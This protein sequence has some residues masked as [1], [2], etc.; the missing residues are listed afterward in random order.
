MRNWLQ[1]LRD[2]F[3]RCE[4]L[5]AEILATVSKEVRATDKYFIEN[6]FSNCEMTYLATS[7]YMAEWLSNLEPQHASTPESSPVSQCQNSF[8]S[9]TAFQLPRI[10]LPKFSGDLGEWE[11]FRDQFKSLINDNNDLVNVNR[12]QYLNSCVKGEAHD[13]I[14][15]LAITDANFKVAWNLLINCYDNHQRLVHEHIHTLHTLPQVESES[16]AALMALRDKANIAIQALRNLG[17]PVDTWD[18]MLIYLLVQKLDKNTR[19]AWE[20]QLDNTTECPSYIQL[21]Q[22]FASRALENILPGIIKAKIKKQNSTSVQSHIAN[23]SSSKCPMCQ[24]S[25]LLFACFKLRNQAC[26]QRREL[27]KK[28]RCCF[29]CLSVKHT[30]D[31]CPN[32]SEVPTKAPRTAS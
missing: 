18:D 13:V 9:R 32:V 7:D 29:N 23:A 1:Q 2:T 26:D 21:E 11:A 6:R 28:F 12:L 31:K 17:R 15:N 4:N 22:F 8:A 3:A 16:A 27:V 10:N 30:R 24:K 19:K 25:H 14:R 5:R 20:L